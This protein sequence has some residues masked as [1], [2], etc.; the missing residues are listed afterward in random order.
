M[1]RILSLKK[2]RKI[3]DLFLLIDLHKQGFSGW[4]TDYRV[5][6]GYELLSSNENDSVLWNKVTKGALTISHCA[7]W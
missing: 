1:H 7:I 3:K 6:G 5:F 2:S 4:N